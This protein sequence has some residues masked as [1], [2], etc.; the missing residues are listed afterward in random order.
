[1]VATLEGYKINMATVHVTKYLGRDI[2]DLS[3]TENNKNEFGTGFIITK[4]LELILE[5][6]KIRLLIQL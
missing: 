2:H 3:Q 1:V 4:K 5:I 6:L